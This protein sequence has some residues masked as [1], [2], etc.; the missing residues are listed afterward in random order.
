MEK[1]KFDDFWD[2]SFLKYANH[3]C[4]NF[5]DLVFNEKSKDQIWQE[6]EKLRITIH[7]YMINPDGRI[8][9]HKIASV[10][11]FAILQVSPFF[12]K[13]PDD[14]KVNLIELAP[15]E[16]FAFYCGIVIIK[17]F[18]IAQAL[19]DNDNERARLFE[20]DFEFPSCPHESYRSHFI[21]NLYYSKINKIIDVFTL[22]NLFFL[23]EKY[24]EFVRT[25][26][27]LQQV[28]NAK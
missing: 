27:K 15:N 12:L 11:I 20:N 9:R 19:E 8:D 21:K 18:I 25:T 14:N 3:L 17:S 1:I 28:H 7:S 5:P 10:L 26:Y 2:N 4:S 16:D 23:I 24:T 6:Y 13:I 22:S